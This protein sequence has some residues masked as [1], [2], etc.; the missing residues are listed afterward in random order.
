MPDIVTF[1]EAMI[2]LS[3]P[4]F[5][6]LEQTSSLDM[7]VGGAELSVAVDLSRLGLSTGWVSVLPDNSL[8][9][10]IR[11]KAREHGVDTSSIV[12]TKNSRAG[13]YFV[14]YGSSPRPSKVTYD[15]ANSAISQVTNEDIKWEAIFGGAK[16]F[17][18]TG[19]TP[20]LSPSAAE[21]TQRAIET[22]KE[23]GLSV[24]YDL[25]YRAKLWSPEDALKTTERYA[26]LIDLCIGNEEDAEKVL[27]IKARALTQ[28]S[29]RSM[30]KAIR[31]SPGRWPAG[32][33]SSM[34]LLRCERANQFF[35]TAGVECFL[36]MASV[37]SRKNTIWKSWTDL[38]AATHSAPV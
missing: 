18:T 8:G 2:R 21:V 17:H 35:K 27:G 32:T 36:R 13:I 10:F 31:K 20:A 19:I 3:P 15:R 30:K 12:F 24:S 14:E 7:N 5:K 29:P 38:A 6:R 25:N 26:H 22:A 23:M 33:V 11:N 9:A 16:W 4:D 37:T 28:T 1:G 34:W